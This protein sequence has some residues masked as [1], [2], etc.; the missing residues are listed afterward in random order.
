MEESVG[1]AQLGS[2]IKEWMT[3]E[4]ELK[5][6]GAEV[7]EKRKRVKMVRQMIVKIMKGSKIGRLNIS[8]GTVT[9]HT[10]NTKAPLS[11]KFLVSALTEFF[12]GDSVKAAACATFLDD[13]RPLKVVENLALDPQSSPT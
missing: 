8:A 9:T 10:K 2:L 4:D 7:R 1:V 13:H 3:T 6:L 12:G 11:K 5:T